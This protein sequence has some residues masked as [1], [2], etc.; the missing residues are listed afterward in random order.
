MTPT[1]LH[2]HTPR[3]NRLGWWL[4]LAAF[5]LT[6]AAYWPGLSGGWLFDDYPNI[7][8]NAGVHPAHANVGTLVNAALSSPASEFKRPL[9]SLSFAV[10]YLFGGL[11]PYG[12]KLVNVIIHLLNGL[13][14]FF[15]A[16]GL[17][18]SVPE[19]RHS[20]VPGGVPL[21]APE[22]GLPA[23][24]GARS[25]AMPLA[26]SD[27]SIARERAPTTEGSLRGSPAHRNNP[28]ASKNT[29]SPLS[30]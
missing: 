16:R 29:S 26:S 17:L 14:V 12:Y 3:F 8:D 23:V 5:A 19:R 2:Q 11:D 21:V 30:K 22:K 27:E 10:N 9:A 15:L 7:V 4:L 20:P 24:V 28:C 25:R 18:R 13:L 6:A 1:V